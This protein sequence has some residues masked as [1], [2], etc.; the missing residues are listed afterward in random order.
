[1]GILDDISNF[2][3]NTLAGTGTHF[4]DGDTLD[5]PDGPNYRLRGYDAAEVSKILYTGEVK[6]GTAGGKETTG[7]ISR[8]ANE[9]GFN[10]IKP[11]FNSDGS[12][13]MDSGGSRQ[14]VD[15]V[16]DVGETFSG[17]LMSSGAVDLTE[18]STDS[19]RIQKTATTAARDRAIFEG[20]YEPSAFDKAAVD[21]EIAERSQGAKSLGFK[22]TLVDEKER[23]SY[24]SYFMTQG[25]SRDQATSEMNKYFYRDVDI[26]RPGVSLD[27]KSL[28]PISDSWEQGWISVGES[29]YGIANLFGS[30]TGAEGLER[31]GEAGVRRQQGK[32]AEFGYTTNNYKDIDNIGGFIEYLGNT[33]ALSLPYMAITAGSALAGTVLAPVVGTALA[34]SGAV[35]IPSFM[36]AGQ[37]WNDMEGDNDSKSA[38]IAI[39]SGIAQAVLDRLGLKGIGGIG[40]NPIQTIREEIPKALA[41]SR[42]ISLLDAKILVKAEADSA[43]GQFAN[44][45]QRIAKAQ[46]T[47]KQAS[48]RALGTVGV[49]SVSEGLTEVGQEAI[50]Y[51][52]AV[53]GSDKVFDYEEFK[54]RLANAAIAGTALGGAFSIPGTVKDQITWMDAAARFGE[55]ISQSDNERYIEEEKANH[56]GT[57][58]TT[59][60]LLSDVQKEVDASDNLGP[61][62]NQRGDKHKQTT[63]QKTFMERASTSVMNVSNLWQAAVTNAIPKATLDKSRSA[64]ALASILGG[65]LTPLH[66]GSGIEAAQHHLVT[67]YKNQVHDPKAY[68]KRLGLRSIAGVFKSSDRARVSDMTYKVLRGAIDK[69]GNFN[70]NLVPK[71]TENRQVIIDLGNQ[72]MTLGKE[73]RQNQLDAGADLGD[74]KG[75]L[76]KYK[77]I[78]KAAVSKDPEKFKNLLISEY[79]ITPDLALR[80]T[81]EIRDNPNVYDLD[82]ADAIISNVGSLN[83]PSHKRRKFG[84]SQNEK[85]DQFYEKDIF[86]NVANASKTAARYVTQMKY[87]GKDGEIISKLLNKMQAEGVPEEEVNRVAS[88]VKNIL[89]AVSGNYNR[90]TTQAGKKLM[91]FQKNVMFWMT[92]SALPLATFSSLPEMAM[93]QGA[94]TKEQ[95]FGKNGSIRNIAQEAVAGLLPNLKKVES[96]TDEGI[97][98]QNNGSEGQKLLRE[99]GFYAWEVG[100]ATTTGVSEVS[101]NRKNVMEAFFRAIGLTQW[102]DYTRA[103]RASMAYDFISINSKILYQR[104]EAR[105][106]TTVDKKTKKKTTVTE[107]VTKD[108]EIVSQGPTREAQEA[109]QKLRSLGIPIE[110]FIPMMNAIE[111]GLPLSAKEMDAWNQ[112]MKEATY[113]FINQ[114]VALPSAANRPLLYQDPRFALFT[115]FQGFISTFTANHIPRMWNDYIK[116]GTPAMKYNTFVLMSTMIALGFFSQAMKDEIKFDDDDDDEGTLGN[117]YLDT[118]EYIR[119]G[120]MSSGLLGTGER[121]VDIFA[122]IYGQRSEGLGGWLYNQATGESP[123]VGYVGRLG[124]ATLNAAKGDFERS[125]YQGLKSAPGIGPFTDTNKRLASLMTGGG[126]NYKDNKEN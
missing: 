38:T 91:R 122:P 12:P 2:K 33:M 100:A 53:Q 9:Q 78:D 49:G 121:I 120:V 90:P 19:D 119:R 113:N 62:V 32:L 103:V 41:K 125:L 15:L 115:Q 102:T 40:K 47:A 66:G 77:S 43:I 82:S 126:W 58:R 93:T 48:M 114:A 110:Q 70:Q 105:T 107:Y 30:S 123:T 24:I 86:A 21:I 75:Y 87:V 95:I 92:L 5:N 28:N 55:P 20:T 44:E 84:L 89:E 26:R 68:Y 54:E 69:R 22:Q 18:Y 116:R 34:V 65:T 63:G 50:G 94:L 67:Y 8:L 46:I 106:T 117:P 39:G 108:G 109:E 97:L 72:L 81:D 51:L 1:M 124:D 6:E 101:D 96:S 59:P 98:Q 74:I 88:E 71:D 35:A 99:T 25:M 111:K 3:P 61:N 17:M 14:M 10:N 29:A 27:N 42:G 79:G 112:T 36:Y 104:N 118:P 64:R 11:V 31:W 85:F 57:V 73:L 13:M 52:A 60:Q 7:I 76:L 23:A 4:I 37:T 45:A 56:G 80:I 83:P 16:N